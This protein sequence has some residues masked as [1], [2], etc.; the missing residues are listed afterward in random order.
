MFN[1]FKKLTAIVVMAFSLIAANVAYSSDKVIIGQLNWGYSKIMTN[2]MKIVA[3]DNYGLQVDMVPGNHAV[4]FKA[5]DQGKGEVDV[6]PEV[7][8]PN[9]QG[10]VDQYVNENQTVALTDAVFPAFDGFCTTQEAVDTYGLKSVYDLTRPE[11][12]ALTDR[13]GNGRGEIWMGAPGWSSTKIHQ[14]RARD[15]G[16]ADLYDLTVSEENVILAQID[17]DA[18]AG[19]V[20]V[21]AC[22]LP[23]H[24][25]GMHPLAVLEEPAHDPEKWQVADLNNDP[26]WLENSHVSTSFPPISSHIAY[27]KRLETDAPEMAKLLNGIDFGQELINEWSF[28]SSVEAVDPVVYAREWVDANKELV[29]SWLG[30]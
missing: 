2:V 20:I 16:F 8:L 30:N 28:A 15:Y 6:H 17:A 24:I 3:E 22:Y 1:T 26:N 7:W 10:L 12:V 18:K 5:M 4:F 19:R 25:F 13:D 27:S 9:N 14:I 11:I 21:W 23:H 29:R